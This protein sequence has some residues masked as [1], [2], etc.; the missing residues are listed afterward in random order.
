MQEATDFA[1]TVYLIG[2]A[3]GGD[4]RARNDLF[5]RYLSRVRQIA[6]LRLN[7]T[8]RSLMDVDDLV[9]DAFLKAIPGFKHFAGTTQATF[10]NYLATCVETALIDTVRRQNTA[11][12]GRRRTKSFSEFG[13]EC[14]SISIFAGEEPTPS[15]I[16]RG[17]ELEQKL[18]QALM[19]LP[20]H[21]REAII[22]RRLCGMTYGEVAKVMN[23]QS[24][25]NARKTC[26]R[27]LFKLKEAL[28]G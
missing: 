15:A 3:R 20:H 24:E 6:G 1:T 28:L 14:L 2:R 13:S 10:L 21:Y 4:L 5:S 18:E 26:S 12:R 8:A 9:Q 23:F 17:K 7:R 11:R 27:G 25:Q 19:G 16:A 22:L